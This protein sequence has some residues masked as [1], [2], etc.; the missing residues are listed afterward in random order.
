[1]EARFKSS[2]SPAT[3]LILIGFEIEQ[4]LSASHGGASTRPVVSRVVIARLG[5]QFCPGIEKVKISGLNRVPCGFPPQRIINP[6][7]ERWSRLK[8]Q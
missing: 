2:L 4:S 7:E 5:L 3:P 6:D 8:C 1:M